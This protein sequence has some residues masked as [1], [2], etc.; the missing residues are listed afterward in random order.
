MYFS[1]ALFEASGLTRAQVQCECAK[2]LRQDW[3]RPG[4]CFSAALLENSVLTRA[5]MQ[6]EFAAWR[7]LG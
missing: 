4:A 1:A 3:T 7:S 2:W 6:Q 5:P